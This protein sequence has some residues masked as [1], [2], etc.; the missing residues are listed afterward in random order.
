MLYFK[1][2]NDGYYEFA[3]DA[4]FFLLVGPGENYLINP[5]GANFS[6]TAWYEHA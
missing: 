6:L 5:G 3:D 2:S 4:P 1:D